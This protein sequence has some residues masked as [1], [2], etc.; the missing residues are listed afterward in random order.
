[1][2]SSPLLFSGGLSLN[3]RVFK[4]TFTTPK[5]RLSSG[6]AIPATLWVMHAPRETVGVSCI[7]VRYD[8]DYSVE[9]PDI[10]IPRFPSC[11]CL[12]SLLASGLVSG[13]RVLIVEK[14]CNEKATTHEPGRLLFKLQRNEAFPSVSARMHDDAGIRVINLVKAWL[15]YTKITRSV[16]NI[17]G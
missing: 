10:F 4:I 9:E 1:M 13:F 17:D 3:L 5:I 2:S 14:C 7:S 12:Q 8:G 15:T 16:G 6:P 11:R